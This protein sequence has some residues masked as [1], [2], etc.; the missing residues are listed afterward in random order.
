MFYGHI[1]G[2]HDRLVPDHAPLAVDLTVD[3]SVNLAVNTEVIDISSPA[4]ASTAIGPPAS[5]AHLSM[6]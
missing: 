4:I 3:L 2:T 6:R 1:A 5:I